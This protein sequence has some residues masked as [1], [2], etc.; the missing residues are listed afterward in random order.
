MI[1]KY[2]Y[3]SIDFN[4]GNYGSDLGYVITKHF[5]THYEINKGVVI[6]VELDLDTDRNVNS[7]TIT[8]VDTEHK[9]VDKTLNEVLEMRLNQIFKGKVNVTDLSYTITDDD[10]LEE[11]LTELELHKCFGKRY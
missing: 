6:N 3:K 4:W 2:Y 9:F 8:I 1:T 11:L 10:K 5:L 7:V